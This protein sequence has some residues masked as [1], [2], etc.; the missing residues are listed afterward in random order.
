MNKGLGTASI[1]REG[2]AMLD[3]CSTQCEGV[4]LMKEIER[5]KG[6][7]RAFAEQITNDYKEIRRLREALADIANIVNPYEEGDT[8]QEI[9]RSALQQMQPS[10]AQMS[11]DKGQQ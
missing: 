1:K 7:N 9:A 6:A 4:Y 11:D 3:M 8:M 10:H 2:Q 5:L